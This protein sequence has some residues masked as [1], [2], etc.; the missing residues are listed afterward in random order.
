VEVTRWGGG[1]QSRQKQ[2][3][4]QTKQFLALT[5]IISAGGSRP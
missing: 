5:V 1:G 4:M 3:N 2:T